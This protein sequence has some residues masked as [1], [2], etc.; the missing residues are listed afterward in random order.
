[1]VPRAALYQQRRDFRV[2]TGFACGVVEKRPPADRVELV[3]VAE[4][5]DVAARVKQRTHYFQMPMRRGPVQR[6]G[7]V[8]LFARVRVGAALEQQPSR[9]QVSALGGGVQP[10]EST[11]WS[12]RIRGMDQFW[13]GVEQQADGVDITFGAG[14]EE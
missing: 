5:V 2:M 7:V 9:I 11:V 6:V 1:M 3:H 14:F 8:A 4:A 13:R 10:G 12:G